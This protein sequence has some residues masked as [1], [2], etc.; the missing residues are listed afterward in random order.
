M[1]IALLMDIESAAGRK[2]KEAL[3]KSPRMDPFTKEVLVMSLD[4]F[5][6]F[7]ITVD[8]MRFTGDG[9][10]FDEKLW[11]HTKP[12]RSKP[13]KRAILGFWAEYSELL[14][15]LAAR[16][17][18][19]NEAQNSVYN[20]LH[21]APDS[22]SRDW[23]IRI[24]NKDLRCGVSTKTAAKVWPNLVKTF[25]IMLANPFD[26]VKHGELVSR[27]I[28]YLEPKFDGMR[29]TIIDGK[30]YS[31]YGHVIEGVDHLLD[32][33]PDL[34]LSRYVLD[35]EVVGATR[36]ESIGSARRKKNKD[37]NT[38][39]KVFDVIMLQEWASRVTR[40]LTQ[41]KLDLAIVAKTFGKKVQAIPGTRVQGYLAEDLYEY[42]DE[43][44]AS[45]F[46][47]GMWKRA[48]ASYPFKRGDDVLKLKLFESHDYEIIDTVEGTGKYK[49]MLGAFVCRLDNRAT[50]NVGSGFTD[51]H[52]KNYWAERRNLVGQYAEVKFQS[53][54]TSNDSLSHPVFMRL[55]KDLAE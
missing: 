12:V 49:G 50:V 42:R 24:L 8:P 3:M 20:M 52:R 21:K 29:V 11:G 28:G 17:L 4:P 14:S 6:T 34:T 16:K 13:T 19:G 45:G 36:E 51:A 7:G 5:T 10:D 55:R 18:R 32:D 31:R 46:E 41:R 37:T 22:E 15:R 1:N 35:C 2:D 40:S 39:L 44:I 26:P 9:D 27:E 30:P 48:D 47:G 25:D 38:T 53:V 43:Q 33:I 54:K 23:A